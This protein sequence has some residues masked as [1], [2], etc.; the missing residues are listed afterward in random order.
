MNLV[1]SFAIAF[2][3]F[4]GV[5]LLYF[6]FCLVL[7][8]TPFPGFLVPSTQNHWN[9]DYYFGFQSILSAFDDFPQS[10]FLNNMDNNLQM[11]INSLGNVANIFHDFDEF[12]NSGNVFNL[13]LAFFNLVTAPIQ[14]IMYFLIITITILEQIIEFIVYA[15]KI[16]S[17]WYNLPVAPFN[18]PIDEADSVLTLTIE[19][20]IVTW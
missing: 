10:V 6:N 5:F 1:K 17:G 16:V 14:A 12:V 3:I 13:L 9:S 4:F 7:N 8:I 20:G 18:T 15:Y 2:L 11:F 19:H